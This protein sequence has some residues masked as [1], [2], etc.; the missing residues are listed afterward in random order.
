MITHSIYIPEYDPDDPLDKPLVVY[1]DSDLGWLVKVVDLKKQSLEYL[2][3]LA[4]LAER[5]RNPDGQDH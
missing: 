1:I 2:A 5:E 4:T 3:R